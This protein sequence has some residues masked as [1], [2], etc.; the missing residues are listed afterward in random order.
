MSCAALSSPPRRGRAICAP[1]GLSAILD[2]FQAVDAV[3]FLRHCREENEHDIPSHLGAGPRG[4]PRRGP[5]A[6][7]LQ[8]P[9]ARRGEPDRPLDQGEPGQ[10]PARE[11]PRDHLH[12]DARARGEE[13]RPG[14]L[15]PRPLPRQPRGDAVLGRPP[16]R[17]RRR[18]PGSPG[19]PT[20]TPGP[21]SSRSTPTWARSRCAWASTRTPGA[22]SGPPSRARTAGFREYKVATIELLPQTENIFLVYKE[23]W[24]NPETH[25]ENPSVERTWTKKEALIS[26]KNPKKDVDRLPRGRHLREVLPEDPRAD[27]H[28]G[29]QRGAAL[30]DRGPAGLPEE[31]PGEGGR[32]R[33]RRVGGP[34][35][36]HEPVLRAQ[37]P[38]PAAQQRRPRARA[39]RLPPLRG[40]RRR[41]AGPVEGVV[42]AVALAPALPAAAAAPAAR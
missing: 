6:A 42:D 23:G 31:D 29:Q 4:R 1:G 2:G 27:R 3:S 14:L 19:R 41:S 22:A 21:A 24:H 34:A 32:P 8:P 15:G 35:P 39:S 25:P 17:A 5:S 40:R 7:G 20:A 38:Q 16:A 28:R 13:A 36:L 26:F 10:G 9:Q 30:P 37:E 11:R 33:Q 18:R 12:L